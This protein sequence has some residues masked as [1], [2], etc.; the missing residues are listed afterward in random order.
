MNAFYLLSAVFCM[1]FGETKT[2]EDLKKTRQE[3]I[4]KL[5]KLRQEYTELKARCRK[6]PRP[7]DT[8]LK[9]RLLN[10]IGKLTKELN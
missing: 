2:P 9:D 4:Q 3:K 7:G 1:T 5:E 8:I 10:E 6:S